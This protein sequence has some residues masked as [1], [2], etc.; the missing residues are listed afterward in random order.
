MVSE[1]EEGKENSKRRN[2][3]TEM[4]PGSRTFKRK[5]L[6]QGKHVHEEQLFEAHF[7]KKV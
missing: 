3:G 6:S 5:K 1:R 4:T 7:K 2:R